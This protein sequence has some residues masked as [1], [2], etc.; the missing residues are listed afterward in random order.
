MSAPLPFL[1]RRDAGNQH[2]ERL[3]YLAAAR[4]IVVGLPRG[5]VPVA[6]LVAA[7]LHAPLDILVV[8]KLGVPNH[9]EFAMGAIGEFFGALTK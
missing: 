8:R 6:A 2:A 9:P 5:G 1:D 4:P 7:R 3:T